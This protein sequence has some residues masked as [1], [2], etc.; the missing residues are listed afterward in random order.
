ML[1]LMPAIALLTWR[2]AQFTRPVQ[3]GLV[4]THWQLVEHP[5]HG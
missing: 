2:C 1:R 4:G 5:V 3:S